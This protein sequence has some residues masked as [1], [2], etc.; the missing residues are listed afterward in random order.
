[1]FP[2]SVF[3]INK[4]NIKNQNIKSWHHFPMYFSISIHSWDV[5]EKENEREKFLDLAQPFQ[6]STISIS[7]LS[8][9]SSLLYWKKG[10]KGCY[11][12]FVPIMEVPNWHGVFIGP[13]FLKPS[14]SQSFS[15]ARTSLHRFKQ[16][17]VPRQ[18]TIPI[19]G[20]YST[21]LTDMDGLVW[22]CI[23]WVQYTPYHLDQFG[24]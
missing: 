18:R 7:L 22:H 14:G 20:Q 5:T 9:L 10:R 17:P 19:F 15:Q 23:P 16:N 24:A 21:I 8:S 4:I 2:N 3:N 12:P 6:S 13:N 11:I 1:M